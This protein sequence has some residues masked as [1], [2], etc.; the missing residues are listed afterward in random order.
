MRI[1]PDW[2]LVYK[3]A[4]N[5]DGTLLFPERLTE[6]FLRK[7]RTTMGPYLFSNQYL[8]VCIPDGMQ[9]FKKHWKRFWHTLPT[10]LAHFAYIDP[11]ISEAATADYTGI[12][13]IAADKDQNWYVRHAKRYRLN[14]TELINTLFKIQEQY[15]TQ[16]I[17][18]ENV[19]FQRA[20]VHFAHEEMKRRNKM[21]AVQGVN[22]G[23]ERTKEMRILSLV[24]RFENGTILLTQGCEDLLRELDEFPRGAHDDVLDALASIESIVTYPRERKVISEPSPNSYD[25]EKWYIENIG[26]R[27]AEPD[28]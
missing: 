22:I 24:P 3:S 4:I 7:A 6:D 20:I 2:D 25:Y 19:A 11:A 15:Q 26:K 8:N 17:G 13:V 14:P 28:Y 16:M 1:N 12:V 27:R 10:P 21:I 23:T 5:D 9:T 18:I